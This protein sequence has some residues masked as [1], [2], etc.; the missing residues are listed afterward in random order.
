[1]TPTPRERVP[2]PGPR[3]LWVALSFAGLVLPFVLLLGG[4]DGGPRA[5]YVSLLFKIRMRNVLHLVAESSGAPVRGE[6][7]ASVASAETRSPTPSTDEG[8]PAQE[9]AEPSTPTAAEDG[10]AGPTIGRPKPSTP[11]P[12]APPELAT[13]DEGKITELALRE[14]LGQARRIAGVDSELG[15]KAIEAVLAHAVAVEAFAMAATLADEV[16]RDGLPLTEDAAAALA[17]TAPATDAAPATHHAAPLADALARAKVVGFGRD[18]GRFGRAR[19]QARLAGLGGDFERARAAHDVIHELEDRAVPLLGTLAQFIGLGALLG[20]GLLFYVAARGAGARTAGEARLDWLRARFAGLGPS[21]WPLDPLLPALGMATWLMGYLVAGVTIA[22]L[23]GPRLAGGL[24]VLFQALFG[25]MAAVAV[26]AAFGRG[27]SPMHSAALVDDREGQSGWR[28]STAALLAYC[29]LLPLMF[30][31]ALVSAFVWSLIAPDMAPHLH[32][33]QGLL[34]QDGGAIDV[35]AMAF[36]VVIAA[37]IGEELVFRGFLYR[38]LRGL[39][40]VRTALW[41]SAAGFAL[42][43]MAL[44][45]LLPYIL[46]GAA[47]ALVFEWTGSLWASITLHALWNGAVLGMLLVVSQA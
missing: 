22:L 27:A 23:P 30:G 7:E 10:D 46:L 17:G 37:P 12:N 39:Y 3:Q 1:M 15:G 19:V 9:P 43:H 16:H 33:V 38:S 5:E 18:W 42:L 31:A 13:L 6:A 28:A 32:P 2:L 4:D 35:G 47:F 26:T 21:P 20:M 44:P 41:I 29:A 8:T 14:L 24:S 45:L 11:A 36:A 25:V 40:G 34:L